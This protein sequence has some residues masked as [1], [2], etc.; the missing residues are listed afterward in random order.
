[1]IGA[2]LPLALHL[3]GAPPVFVDDRAEIPWIV[4]VTPASCGSNKIAAGPRSAKEALLASLPKQPE[5]KAPPKKK[6]SSTLPLLPSP[7]LLGV[8]GEALVVA[9][10]KMLLKLGVGGPVTLRLDA[11]GAALELPPLPPQTTLSPNFSTS[12]L[13]AI[14]EEA[15]ARVA[16][17]EATVG[18][19]AGAKAQRSA[20]FGTVNDPAVAAD[21]G[22]RLRARFSIAVR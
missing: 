4:V 11:T 22:R 2:A 15:A 1:M 12:E 14:V 21:F 13:N 8:E 6:A 16:H 9:A 18:A 3:L 20:C 5:Q 17:R 19:A 7:G 10:E